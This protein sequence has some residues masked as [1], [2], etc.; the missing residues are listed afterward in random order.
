MK[1]KLKTVKNPYKL[2]LIY[3]VG[4]DFNIVSNNELIHYECGYKFNIKHKIDFFKILYKKEQITC[5]HCNCVK[6]K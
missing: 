4:N 3:L 2:L 1:N 6:N 5:P